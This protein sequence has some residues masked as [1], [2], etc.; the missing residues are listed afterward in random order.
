MK[1]VLITGITGYIGSNLARLL[2][3]DHEVFGLAREPLNAF[4]IKD[5]QSDLQLFPYDG[6]YR[7]VENALHKHRPELVYHLAAY[8]TGSHGASETPALIESNITFGAYLL[9]AMVQAHSPALVYA[10]TVMS[11]YM[12]EAYRP[13]NLYSATKRA[14]FD[15]L[16]YYTDAGLLRAVTLV[17][18][19][20]YG[21]GDCRPKILNLIKRAAYT[22]EHIAL[23][24]GGQDF[25][26]VYIDDVVRAFRIAGEL[27]V[28]GA[29]T[30]MT[31]Q[32]CSEAPKTLR[33]T[34][35]QMLRM[36]SASPSIGWGERPAVNREMRQAVRVAPPL[37]G[38]R[39]EI[40]LLE[41]LRRFWT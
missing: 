17:L 8:Y 30:N 36:N 40:S 22:G 2:L 38:W 7:S 6:S 31:F 23:S 35:E 15:L 39:Q 29:C 33:D 18:S 9:E 11:N 4:Y 10:T 5:I 1:R 28:E 14:L 12:G 26:V 32:V 21:S 19:D 37:P 3:P 34:V 27:A 24:D 20:T 16:S 25:D 13:L 41:G